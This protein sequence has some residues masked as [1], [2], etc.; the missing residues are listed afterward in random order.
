MLQVEMLD[1]SNK[2]KV[3][4]FIRLPFRLYK[5]C[6]QWCPPFISDIKTMLDRNKHPYY[7]HSDA[8]FF[9][10]RRDGQVVGRIAAMENKSFNQYHGTKKGQFYLFECENDLDAARMLFGR[11]CEWMSDRGLTE[12]VGPKGFSGFD[13][14]GIQ[15]EGYEEHQMMI[16]MNYNYPYYNDLMTAMGFEKEVD[17]VSCYMHRDKFVLPDKINRVLEIIKKRG[18]FKVKNFSSRKELLEWAPRIGDAYNRS[19]INNWEYYPMT[20]REIKFAVEGVLVVA[21]PKLI[22]IITYEDNICG[23]LFGFP[24]ISKSMQR[25]KGRL[26]PISIA[27]MMISLKTTNWISLNGVGV[28]PEYQGTGGNVILYDETVKTMKDFG[29]E[30]AELTQMAETATQVRRDIITVGAKPYKNHRIYHK[31]I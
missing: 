11:A 26:N 29:Y 6:P 16:M 27:D 7:E 30:H 23:F 31:K 18:K 17:F 1:T 13:G 9:V 22:K 10:V 20:Q 3:D 8:D 28:L 4:E 21:N 24:D 15:V 25:G 2:A 5:D 12:I 14:Y 19:F